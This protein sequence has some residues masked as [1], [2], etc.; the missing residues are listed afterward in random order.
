MNFT[1]HVIS[2]HFAGLKY[3]GSEEFMLVA[4]LEDSLGCFLHFPCGYLFWQ[5]NKK[6]ASVVVEDAMLF[7]LGVEGWHGLVEDM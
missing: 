3:D 6:F 1:R 2:T 4:F 7:I 5:L